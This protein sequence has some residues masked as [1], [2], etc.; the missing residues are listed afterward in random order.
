V[1]W[2]PSRARDLNVSFYGHILG[3]GPDLGMMLF[4]GSGKRGRFVMTF[5]GSRLRSLSGLERS[6]GQHHV[7]LWSGYLESDRNCVKGAK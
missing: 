6:K 3:A 4:S 7:P 5:R 1:V 2:Q